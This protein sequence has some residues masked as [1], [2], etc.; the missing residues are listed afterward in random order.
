MIIHPSGK[1]LDMFA[2]M[3][4]TRRK[5]LGLESDTMLRKRLWDILYPN[6]NQH[7]NKK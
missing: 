5:W 3:L 4:G 6:R 7:N 2:S 1:Q